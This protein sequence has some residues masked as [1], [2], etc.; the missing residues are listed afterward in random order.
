MF[1]FLFD[2]IPQFR[3]VP[4]LLPWLAYDDETKTF[5]CDGNCIGFTFSSTPMSGFEDT[6]EKRFRSLLNFEFPRGTFLQF[7]LLV[8]DDVSKY[9]SDLT[10]AV[11]GQTITSSIPQLP[12]PSSSSAVAQWGQGSSRSAMPTF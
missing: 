4:D 3:R 9:I 7:N 6:M 10:Q 5:V 12:R 2:L 11:P 1:D 8:F